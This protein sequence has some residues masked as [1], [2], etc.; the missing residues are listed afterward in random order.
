MDRDR[1]KCWIESYKHLQKEPAYLLFW[2]Y[3][4]SLQ[5][6][7]L[8]LV[9]LQF[10]RTLL[11]PHPYHRPCT[12]GG[13]FH[14]RNQCMGVCMAGALYM[15]HC[16]VPCHTARSITFCNDGGCMTIR[17]V[18]ATT[19]QIWLVYMIILRVTIWCTVQQDVSLLRLQPKI[20]TNWE[21]SWEAVRL[22]ASGSW[23]L[24]HEHIPNT[25]VQSELHSLWTMV[26]Q[27]NLVQ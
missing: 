23:P 11:S 21:I 15:A 1:R 19:V 6:D 26:Y 13:T 17:T 5:C 3:R 27:H 22:Q 18:P 20:W 24:E 2:K 7:T 16:K 14:H 12:V 10:P 8:H 4:F 25:T 9:H